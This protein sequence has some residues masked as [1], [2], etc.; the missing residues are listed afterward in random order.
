[1]A[2]GLAW[3]AIQGLRGIPD[4]NGKKTSIGTAIAC[5]ILAVLVAAGAIASPYLISRK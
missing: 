2:I 3:P 4:P 1:M 5:L